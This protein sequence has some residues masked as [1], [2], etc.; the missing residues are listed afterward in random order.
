MNKP[1]TMTQIKDMISEYV[2]DATE[3][4]TPSDI[5][6]AV[7]I[8][9][10]YKRAIECKV[11]EGQKRSEDEFLDLIMRE[12]AAGFENNFMKKQYSSIDEMRNE[13]MKFTK[14]GVGFS[15]VQSPY[16]YVER[17]SGKTVHYCYYRLP[18]LLF[19]QYWDWRERQL[20]RVIYDST[21]RCLSVDE[22]EQKVPNYDSPY[23]KKARV[24]VDYMEQMERLKPRGI[25]WNDIIA[26]YKSTYD[27]S[28]VYP[29]VYSR[30]EQLSIAAARYN[31]EI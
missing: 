19:A 21:L 3:W 18:E 29:R 30:T 12:V 7:S 28:V 26:K 31:R 2:N 14:G 10:E 8:L 4:A 6:Q 22:L 20:V 11:H 25:E 13:Y 27:P 17:K 1:I 23:Y 15:M 5:R 9:P 24:I 16:T